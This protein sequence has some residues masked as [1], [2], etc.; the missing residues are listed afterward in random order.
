MNIPDGPSVS[1]S[2]RSRQRDRRSG[3]AVSSQPLSEYAALYAGI[4]AADSTKLL[5]E[6]GL[7][8]ANTLK[9]ELTNSYDIS[10]LQ[11]LEGALQ[12]LPRARNK[13]IVCVAQ[14]ISTINQVKGSLA[15]KRT[16]ADEAIGREVAAGSTS[17]VASIQYSQKLERLEAL[18]KLLHLKFQKRL[19]ALKAELPADKLAKLVRKNR[20]VDFGL[21]VSNAELEALENEHRNAGNNLPIFSN[22]GENGMSLSDHSGSDTESISSQGSYDR[23][24]PEKEVQLDNSEYLSF[25]TR[26][27]ISY[28]TARSPDIWQHSQGLKAALDCLEEHQGELGTIPAVISQLKNL[29]SLICNLAK[30]HENQVT[31]RNRQQTP[32]AAESIAKDQAKAR[33]E[34]AACGFAMLKRRFQYA[35][36]SFEFNK[37]QKEE[38]KKLEKAFPTNGSYMSSRAKAGATFDV[39]PGAIGSAG[40][41]AIMETRKSDTNSLMRIKEGRFRLGAGAGLSNLLYGGGEVVAG[42]LTMRGW[43]GFHKRANDLALVKIAN[44]LE[45]RHPEAF[46]QKEAKK[47]RQQ[48][49]NDK[50][51]LEQVLKQASVGDVTMRL[52]QSFAHLP[53]QWNE[54]WQLSYAKW[55]LSGLVRLRKSMFSGGVN[56]SG[57]G[58]AGLH[59]TYGEKTLF[60][61]RMSMLTESPQLLTKKRFQQEVL[62]QYMRDANGQDLIKLAQ[63]SI[64]SLQASD[65]LTE[66]DILA[67]KSSMKA[68]LTA[69]TAIKEDFRLYCLLVKR[70]DQTRSLGAAKHLEADLREKK[71]RLENRPSTAVAALERRVKNIFSSKEGQA[72]YGAHGRVDFIK[73]LVTTHANMTVN[74]VPIFHN[75]KN[76]LL[77]N[78]DIYKTLGKAAADQLSA[79]LT[80]MAENTDKTINSGRRSLQSPPLELTSDQIEKC[81]RLEEK[82]KVYSVSQKASAE[83]N[84][85]CIIPTDLGGLPA[86]ATA[87]LEFTLAERIADDIPDYEGLFAY[88]DL[89][90]N[91]QLRPDQY[92]F[93]AAKIVDQAWHIFKKAPGNPD[94]LRGRIKQAIA[95]TLRFRHE[96][97]IAVP[98]GFGVRVKVEMRNTA[99]KGLRMLDTKMMLTKIQG[100]RWRD[101]NVG[102]NAAMDIELFNEQARKV[103]QIWGD[104]TLFYALRQVH[105]DWFHGPGHRGREKWKERVKPHND[106]LKNILINMS[107]HNNLAHAEYAEVKT[108]LYD[109]LSKD[110]WLMVSK[111]K[112]VS[113]QQKEIF[114]KLQKSDPVKYKNFITGLDSDLAAKLGL[115]NTQATEIRKYIET[116][117]SSIS[118]HTA[119]LD[120]TIE[121]LK[122]ASTENVEARLN[123]ALDE[124]YKFAMLDHHT[125][126]EWAR[127][128]DFYLPNRA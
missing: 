114:K 16:H 82:K 5:V 87:R 15:I 41:E 29:E 24:F 32:S 107:D 68:I 83:I 54:P 85:D 12:K 1:L 71:I 47:L 58:K 21:F 45:D 77:N 119:L 13:G 94:H 19:N 64:K 93:A 22:D 27:L 120:Q 103:H 10:Q 48:I 102:P 72:D 11:S 43:T 126:Y 74:L 123:L 33:L 63:R 101:V 113:F 65:T 112:Y 53:S 60:S 46:N 30:A 81:L 117:Y 116:A 110:R 121:N 2:Q 89:H 51:Q 56:L 73:R 37:L 3:I 40:G 84:L 104:N 122:T 61:E 9:S 17:S 39:S 127:K 55:G 25:A 108:R 99:K 28:F 62:Q 44:I 50:E 90:I 42:G 31:I 86:G 96:D 118:E 80:Q 109:Y 105:G 125:S 69:F 128:K 14:L 4:L 95:G 23:N 115:S 92:T 34:A 106:E 36:Y 78:T 20:E 6:K 18:T 38:E 98:N 8:T 57:H 76:Q 49:T 59:F 75:L 97:N 66:T 35:L 7:A 124:F 26:Q 79:D 67:A 52:K 88:I 100:V 111:E 91:A 70:L